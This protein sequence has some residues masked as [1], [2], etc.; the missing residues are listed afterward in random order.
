VVEGDHYVLVVER[1]ETRGVNPD[2]ID[3]P[4]TAVKSSNEPV[5]RA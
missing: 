4:P 5:P 1:V 2:P 3:A